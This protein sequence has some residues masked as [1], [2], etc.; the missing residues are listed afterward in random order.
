MVIT[1]DIHSLTRS[2]IVVMTR[3]QMNDQAVTLIEPVNRK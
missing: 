2:S 1:S 3:L